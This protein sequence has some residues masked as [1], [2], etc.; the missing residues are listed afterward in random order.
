[1]RRLFLLTLPFALAACTAT[2]A[3]GPALPGYVDA[4]PLTLKVDSGSMRFTPSRP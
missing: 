2:G 1:M 4:P 3:G